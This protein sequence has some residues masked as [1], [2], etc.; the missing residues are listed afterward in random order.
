MKQKRPAIA[1]ALAFFRRWHKKYEAHKHRRDLAQR[2]LLRWRYL[3]GLRLGLQR[4]Y[5]FFPLH[6]MEKQLK[7]ER[8]QLNETMGR[9]NF[10]YK[11]KNTR[12]HEPN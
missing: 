6:K 2:R 5:L 4:Y 1:T 8:R 9:Y 12:Q 11:Q 10:Q 7:K 3:R